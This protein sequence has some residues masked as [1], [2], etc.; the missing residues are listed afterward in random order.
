MPDRLASLVGAVRARLRVRAIAQ[1]T[2][3][4]GALFALLLIAGA[5]NAVALAAAAVA[6]LVIAAR[7][8]RMT[9]SVVARVIERQ[10]PLDNLL[11]TAAEL[12]ERPRPVAAE[13]RDAIR[14]QAA[15]RADRVDAAQVVQVGQAVAAAVAVLAGCVLLLRAGDVSQVVQQ[16]LVGSTDAARS[17]NAITV[18]VT[19]PPYTRRPAE[20]HDNPTQVSVMAGSAVRV[21]AAS[22]VVREWTATAS[23]SL[24]LRVAEDAPPRFLS[25]VVVPDAAP[26]VRIVEPGRDTAFASPAGTIRLGVESRDDVGITSLVLRYTKASGGGEN[27]TFT[28]G[29][30][31]MAIERVSERYW[32][33][34]AQWAIDALDLA[35]GDV[36]VYR[37]IARDANPK[38]SA[39]ES[40]AYLIEIG[41][42]AEIASAGFALPSEEKKYA[43][44]QQMVIYKTEQLINQRPQDWLEQTRLIAMEQ[45]MVRAEVVFL[46]GGEVQDEV[47][48]AAHSHE[49]AEGRLENQGRAEMVR[50][51]NLM[52][53]AEAQ[54]ND[55]NAV[56]AL[57]FERQALASLE[58]ALDRRRYF[59]RTLPDRSRIDMTRRLTGERREARTWLRPRAE[60]VVPQTTRLQAAMQGLVAA[61]NDPAAVN[62][63]L[64][65]QVA[66]VA[67]ASPDLQKAAV[68][69]ANAQ[70]PEQQREAAQAAMASLTAYALTTL[71]GSTTVAIPADPLAG[72]LSESMRGRPR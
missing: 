37:A 64:A 2:T 68:A 32:R 36:L 26:T 60:P 27:V 45:R 4:G 39:V 11:V 18:R 6:A 65:A 17:S 34:S 55:G 42:T 38:G 28:D 10:R 46:S 9:G 44:S 63:S 48:E 54:L 3:A 47:E 50:A 5:A 25:V 23:E 1:A 15:E 8:W 29:E 70:T 67:P 24:E 40:D 72:A 66:A 7:Q 56:E 43:I 58:R 30:V 22:R 69:I 35:D 20:T 53:R 41:R 62:A 19:P 12:D 61:L 16:A 33:A 31:P 21:D 52:S 13:I 71:P 57:V 14:Q 51:L 59:L 49:L